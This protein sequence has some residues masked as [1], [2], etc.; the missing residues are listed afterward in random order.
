MATAPVPSELFLNPHQMHSVRFV[1]SFQK[2]ASG[3][4]LSPRGVG[5]SLWLVSLLKSLQLIQMI[6]F[7]ICQSLR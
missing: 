1:K 5:E 2:M 7:L 6:V 3:T 4:H